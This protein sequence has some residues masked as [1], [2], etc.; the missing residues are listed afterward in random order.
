MKNDHPINPPDNALVIQTVDMHT[1]GEPL[2]VIIEGI[3]A[4]QGNSVLEYRQHLQRHCD[5]LRTALMYEPRGHADMYGCIITPSQQAD[6]GVVFMHNE[7]YSTMCGHAT[8]ALGRLA[9][10]AGWVDAHDGEITFTMEAPCGII[11]L[12]VNRVDGR[13][14]DVSFKNVPSFVTAADKSVY[15]PSFGEIE[16]HVAYGGAFY[17]IVEAAPLGLKLNRENAQ[18]LI[19]AGKQIKQAIID[20]EPVRHP[21]EKDLSFLYGTIFVGPAEKPENHSRNICIFADGE[22]DRSPTGSGVSAR[23]AL[24]HHRSELGPDQW[25][26]VESILGTEFKGRIVETGSYGPYSAVTPQV[27]GTAYYTGSH[28]FWIDPQDPLHEGFLLR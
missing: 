7:G 18:V 17:A 1:A 8:I 3:P 9:V 28:Q 16:Y 26:T 4:L 27:Q 11:T 2:R 13:V 22:L 10:E 14:M 24:L 12:Q 5:H 23:M 15:V 20:L 21:F 19:A 25:I 6:F